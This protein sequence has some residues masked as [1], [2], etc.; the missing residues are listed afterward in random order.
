MT[1]PIS[2]ASRRPSS[3]APISE[4]LSPDELQLYSQLSAHQQKLVAK[5]VAQN[6][7]TV[8]ASSSSIGSQM[9]PAELKEFNQLPPA[10]QQKAALWVKLTG[11]SKGVGTKTVSQLLSPAELQKYNAMSPAQ[12]S[13][14][15]FEKTLEAGSNL[16]GKAGT[17]ANK[18]LG[19]LFKDEFAPAAKPPLMNL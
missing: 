5:W 10:V 12:Q 16:S 7:K 4:R 11:G 3:S 17:S 18:L 1:Q 13:T 8:H 6:P 2:S 19:K 14:V 9:S 15:L